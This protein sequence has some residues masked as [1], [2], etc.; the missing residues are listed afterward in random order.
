VDEAHEIVASDPGEIAYLT[1][2]SSPRLGRARQRGSPDAYA[3]TVCHT[4]VPNQWSSY[5]PSPR[6]FVC[7][8]PVEA[9]LDAA[10]SA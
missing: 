9:S 6:L 10:A 5:W 7:E 8:A 2:A 4:D 3:G 1:V